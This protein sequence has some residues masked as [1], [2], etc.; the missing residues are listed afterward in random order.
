VFLFGRKIET[1]QAVTSLNVGGDGDLCVAIFASKQTVIYDTVNNQSGAV[2][3]QISVEFL[4]NFDFELDVCSQS[5]YCRSRAA[6]HS[7]SSI[8]PASLRAN[9]SQPRKS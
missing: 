7:L 4:R 3:S 6:V 9:P 1:H 2:E 8:A 5:L